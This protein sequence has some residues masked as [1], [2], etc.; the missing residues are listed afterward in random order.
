MEKLK[1]IGVLFL[2]NMP[3]VIVAIAGVIANG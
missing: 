3:V 2:A 1:K